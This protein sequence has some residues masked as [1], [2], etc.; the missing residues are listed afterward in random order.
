MEEMFD[1]ADEYEK[2]LDKGISASGEKKDYF[3]K[4][5]LDDLL[6]QLPKEFVPRKIL[7]YGCGTGETSVLLKELFPT[8]NVV[9]SEISEGSLE[10]A[11][12]K[13]LREG[14]E[15][16]HIDKLQE[17]KG[18]FDL[19]YTNGVFHHIPLDQRSFSYQTVYN[20]LKPNG[21]FGYFE[22]N[23]YNP[24]TRY[25]MSRVPFDRDAITITY[26]EGKGDLKKVGFDI[27]TCNFLF[28]F[29]RSL[30]FLRGLE[31]GLKSIPLGGQY[32]ILAHK[33]R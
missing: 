17:L 20:C 14:I 12:K 6:N 10:Y 1:L 31:K 9:G 25:I 4:G 15:F 33:K 27:V 23:P 7:D 8:A 16:V 19:A 29:P 5:R 18:Q 28:Y 32:H 22:N 26:K 3:I 21:Y 11:K 2:M 24:G 13:N 30:K